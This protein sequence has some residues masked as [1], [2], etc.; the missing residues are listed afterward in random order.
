M[1]TTEWQ[2]WDGYGLTLKLYTPCCHRQ[3]IQLLPII[4]I[5]MKWSWDESLVVLRGPLCLA[6]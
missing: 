2:I 5:Y 1:E 6:L 3:L 4:I